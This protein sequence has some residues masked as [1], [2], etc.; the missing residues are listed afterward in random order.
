MQPSPHPANADP[1]REPQTLSLSKWASYQRALD[2]IAAHLA[3]TTPEEEEEGNS[4]KHS[5]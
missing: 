2:R 5:G 4:K 1:L 3:R